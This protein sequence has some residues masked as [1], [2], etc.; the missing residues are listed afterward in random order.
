MD[1]ATTDADARV[2]SLLGGKYQLV[3]LIGTG[4]MGAVYEALNTWTD[5]RV[6][7]KVLHAEFAK[8]KEVT[9][10]F[11][12]EAKAATRIAHPNIVDVL[13][14]GEDPSDG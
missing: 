4:G 11:M 2:G 1:T 14:L 7:I 13:D 3:R 12:Q 9:Q 5:R 8:R 6:A 10:R